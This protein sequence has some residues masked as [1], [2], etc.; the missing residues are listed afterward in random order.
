MKSASL[1]KRGKAWVAVL[2]VACSLLGCA[3]SPG[4]ASSSGDLVT[5][6]DETE[7]RK[8]ARIRLELAAGY[9]QQDRT[10]IALDEVKQALVA[11]PGFADAHNLRGL[12]YMKLNETGLAEESFRRALSLS[13]QD[14]AI[15]HNYGWFLCQ[16]RRFAPAH[17]QFEQALGSRN[18]GDAGRT[19]M[20]MAL[21]AQ[22]DGRHADTDKYFQRAYELDP[23]NPIVGYNLALLNYKRA[24]YGRSQ[25]YVRRINSG[26]F[27]NAQTLWLGVK[28]ERK[29]GNAAA[30]RAV[31]DQLQRKFS[32]SDEARKYERGQ[33]DD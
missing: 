22:A 10:T 12:I 7:A 5:A 8:R 31:A 9:F 33:F 26:E 4:N 14:G 28:I 24:E 27:A 17:A 20:T 16:Q 1:F 11:D 6:S 13:S 21:C 30:Y 32:G 3:N 25:F 15:L 2:G 29:L 18:Y 23:N 19:Y